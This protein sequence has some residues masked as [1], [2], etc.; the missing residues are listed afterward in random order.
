MTRY[1]PIALLGLALVWGATACAPKLVGPTPTK[2]Y[3]VSVTVLN[4]IIYTASSSFSSEQ[5]TRQAVLVVRVQH[6]QGQPLDDVPVVFEVAP[7]W[8]PS[9]SVTPPHG[10]TRN[11]VVRTVFESANIG[12]V[13]ITVRVDGMTQVAAVA[14]QARPT[15]TS[16]GGV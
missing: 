4:P 7:E 13:R 2:G 9:T 6:A 14:V 5:E 8:A 10:T 12:L 11:G 3:F 1:M 16:H 15:P